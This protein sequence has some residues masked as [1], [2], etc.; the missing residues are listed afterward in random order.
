MLA[1]VVVAHARRH[2]AQQVVQ[3]PGGD[4]RA[5][6]SSTE[7]EE[8][9]VPDELQLAAVD[10]LADVV[11]Q[12]RHEHPQPQALLGRV[13][14][15]LSKYDAYRLDGPFLQ[16]VPPPR[17]LPGDRHVVGDDVELPQPPGGP[18]PG[19]DRS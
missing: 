9:A 17:V 13:T 15:D 1:S 11:A 16:H 2:L 19:T 6:L 18:T 3:R 5:A 10:D 7:L 4:G 8:P 14:I 12:D